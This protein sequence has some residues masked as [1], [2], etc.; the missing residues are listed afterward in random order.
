MMYHNKYYI[1]HK[2]C[3][4]ALIW[5]LLL[6]IFLLIFLNIAFN[7]KYCKYEKTVGYI[8]KI[9]DGYYL[10]TYVEDLSIYKYSLLIE[11]RELSFTIDSISD[12]YYIIDGKKYYEVVLSTELD[13]SLLIENNIIDIVFKKE[14]TTLF[15]EFKKGMD[16]WLN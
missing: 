10:S 9:N 15:K 12:N 13:R 16:K 11:N 6:I 8:K 3:L 5:L 4:A 2:K 1:A 14:E 7:Y